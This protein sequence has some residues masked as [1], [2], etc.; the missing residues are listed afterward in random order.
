LGQ[1]GALQAQA[2][3]AELPSAA[4]FDLPSAAARFSPAAAGWARGLASSV[5]SVKPAQVLRPAAL[6]AAAVQPRE[7][8]DAVAGPRREEPAVPR[9]L[10]RAALAL[11]GVAA[12]AQPS[13]ALLSAVLLSAVLPWAAP[14]SAVPFFLPGPARQPAARSARGIEE[15][16]IASRQARSWQAARDEVL[17]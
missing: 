5:V 4:A 10:P 8:P 14:P 6:D 13:V 11:P 12:V 2:E 16:Q 1:R 7:V 9:A 3:P 15:L 17:S